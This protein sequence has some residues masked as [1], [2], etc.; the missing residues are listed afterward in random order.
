MVRNEFAHFRKEEHPFIERCLDWVERTRLS[1][2]YSLTPFLDPRQQYILET[3]ANQEIET[4]LY[5]DGGYLEAERKR[6]L[7]VP[8]YAVPG[9]DDFMLAFMEI[10]SGGNQLP[11]KH[12]DVLGSMLGL[13]IRRDQLG[14]ITTSSY[15]SHI[16]LTQEMVEYVSAH[17]SH[18]GSHRVMPEPLGRDQ[19]KVSIPEVKERQSSV[20]SLRA[21]TIVAEGFGISRSKSS[22]LIRA[23]K[24][25]INWKTIDSPSYPI[26][27]LDMISLT[28]FGRVKVESIGGITKKDRRWV[29]LLR[30][31]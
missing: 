6:A 8:E 1:H 25:R 10:T 31:I 2:K 14:D 15:H 16:I 18:V 26:A 22:Q 20:A 27:P 5:F 24:C 9:E 4:K 13:G 28:G 29:N 23:Q 19:L 7:I 3:I 11:W 12:K 21:D 30:Y 17:L